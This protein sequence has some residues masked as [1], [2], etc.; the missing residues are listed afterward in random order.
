[1][2]YGINTMKFYAFCSDGSIIVKENHILM[3]Y[4]EKKDKNGKEIYEG[5]SYYCIVR[6]ARVEIS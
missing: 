6:T 5:V 3:Q 2:F 1:M 4:I